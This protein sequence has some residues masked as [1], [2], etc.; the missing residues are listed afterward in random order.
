[1]GIRQY[2]E[3]LDADPAARDAH[4][5]AVAR[6]VAADARAAEE[7]QRAITERSRERIRALWDR[8]GKAETAPRVP[9]LTEAKLRA[10]VAAHPAEAAALLLEA[11]RGDAALRERLKGEVL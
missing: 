5:A 10:W 1:M 9:R 8:R 11:S 6:L 3:R 7:E 2:R 4:E